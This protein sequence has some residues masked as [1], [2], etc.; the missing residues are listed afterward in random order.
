MSVER[1]GSRN[2]LPYK[3]RWKHAGVHHARRFATATAAEKFDRKVKDLKAAGELHVLDEEPRGT[4]TL[5]DYV[6][7]VW[8]PDYAEV[9]LSD[10]GRENYSVQLDLRIIPKW[11]GHQLRHLR[12]GPIEA[13]VSRLRKQGVGDPTIVKTLTV[14]RSILKRAERDEQIDRNPI[15]SSQSPSSSALASRDRSRPTTSS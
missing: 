12:P 9:N 7:E 6:Y 14:F 3:V 10:E 15:P 8:W 1:T 5:R 2:G 11:G 13:W 4:V